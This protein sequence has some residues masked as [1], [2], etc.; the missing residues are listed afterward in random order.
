MV[1]E[2]AVWD[3]VA[4]DAEATVGDFILLRS[5]GVPMYNFCVAVDDAAMGITMVIRAEIVFACTVLAKQMMETMRDAASNAGA[6][7]GYNL[8]STFDGLPYGSEARLMVTRR[9]FHAI[10]M[11]LLEV[12][13]G[14]SLPVP[15]P[16]DPEVGSYPQEYKLT[17]KSMAREM[18][19]KGKNLFHPVRRN[20]FC[21]SGF[22]N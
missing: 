4:W 15:R 12:H 18:D 21:K 14:G 22:V 13:D 5:S 8:P 17:M 3:T 20:K 1:I 9:N 2:D 11:R 6:V 7:L 19:V 10:A 16:D